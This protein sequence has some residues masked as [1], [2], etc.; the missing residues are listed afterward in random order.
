M[1]EE[2]KDEI[3]ELSKTHDS[4]LAKRRQRREEILERSRRTLEES[5]SVC[6]WE[7]EST[8]SGS[9]IPLTA[10]WNMATGA[11][12]AADDTASMLSMQSG[13]SAQSQARSAQGSVQ[14]VPM[15]PPLMPLPNMQG[16]GGEGIN[17]ASIQNWIA[18][19]VTETLIQ[20]QNEMQMMGGSLPPSRAGSV[21][22]F[23][24]CSPAGRSQDDDKVS[25]LSGASYSSALS[26]GGAESVLSAG[27]TSSISGLGSSRRKVTK[28]SVPLY[29]L[30]QD[31]VNLRKLDSMDKEMKSEMR[32]KMSTYELQKIASD[33]KR[34]T[35]FKKKKVKEENDEDGEDEKPATSKPAAKYTP[36]PARDRLDTPSTRTG[37]F[38]S[39]ATER[40]KVSSIDKWL[41]DIK[42]PS[43]YPRAN[44][45]EN[46]EPRTSRSSLSRE[47]VAESSDYTFS[48]RREYSESSFDSDGEDFDSTSRFSS[49]DVED[50]F[51]SNRFRGNALD[52][53]DHMESSSEPSYHSR[54]APPATELFSN[55]LKESHSYRMRRSSTSEEEEEEEYTAKRTFARYSRNEDDGAEVRRRVREEEE[56]EDEVSSFI[57]R[58]RLRSRTP[59]DEDI[60]EDDVIAAWRRQQESKRHTYR[61]SDS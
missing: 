48:R 1:G 14:S 22:S 19:V 4:A 21:L 29:S 34:S 41:N 13:R 45:T 49:G 9:T 36:A 54:R 12:S 59:V 61:G 16:V 37:R 27:G 8:L 25:M 46:T 33:N 39:S 28:T 35:L 5:Q 60:D 32:D 55:G 24:G 30:F 58:C 17:L 42:A 20:K 31:Q 47:Q 40:D 43:R 57:S 2:D 56:E 10:F 38:S 52:A 6:G 51:P 53:N 3:V 11:K 50:S 7:T 18:N 15:T 23:G 26:R 44:G